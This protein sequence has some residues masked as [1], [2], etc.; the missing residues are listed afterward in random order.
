MLIWTT[1]F[2][3]K[4]AVLSVIVMGVVMAAL[5]LLTGRT[6]SEKSPEPPTLIDNTQRI[7]YLQSLGWEV[8]PEPIE[9]LQF[10]LPNTLND[11]YLAYN[12]L[13]QLQ[14]FDLTNYGGKQVTRYTYAV[15]NYPGRSEGVQANLYVCEDLPVAGDICCPGESG[16]Q[17]ALIQQQHNT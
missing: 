11:Y 6:N 1:R 9:T 14:G 10:L 4:K 7:A 3:K 8:T 16:F 17:E 15:I 13:Q 12:Q 5:I 2:S